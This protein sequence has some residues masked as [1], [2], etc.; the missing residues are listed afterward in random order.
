MLLL[1]KQ[2]RP[3][4]GATLT[5]KGSIFD[6][7]VD[8]RPKSKTFGKYFSYILNCDN[9]KMLYIPKGFA[10]GFMTM[11]N[12]TEILYNVSELYAPDKEETIIWNDQFL[13][14]EW[15]N[16]PLELSAKDIKGINFN[17]INFDILE[18]L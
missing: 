7:I 3:G 12:N 16:S 15:P 4:I 17:E 9:N 1:K 13:N 6:V 11:E 10:H 18:Q 2:K 14:I 5:I 8:I